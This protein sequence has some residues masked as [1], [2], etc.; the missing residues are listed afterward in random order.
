MHSVQCTQC[1]VYS[2]YS[3][4]FTV[5]SISE[6]HVTAAV[7]P[8]TVHL[9][10]I[11]P[12][13]TTQSCPCR[14]HHERSTGSSG[15]APMFSAGCLVR[16]HCTPCSLQ[17]PVLSIT[18]RYPLYP[19]CSPYPLCLLHA[20]YHCTPCTAVSSARSVPLY[21]LHSCIFCTLCTA[22]SSAPPVKPFLNFQQFNFAFCCSLHAAS[23]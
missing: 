23:N 17:P 19:V 5:Y 15:V 1:T 4:Q 6:F 10:A 8:I 13:S 2:V 22:V 9:T 20:L 7:T 3:V 14:P 11:C 21:S 18:C 12:Y 16:T